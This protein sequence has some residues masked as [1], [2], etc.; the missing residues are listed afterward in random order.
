MFLL[1]P[2]RR[3]REV[4][5]YCLAYAARRTGMVLH[6]VVVMSNH[7]HLVVTDPL[8]ALP[9]FVECL[10]KLVA[11]SLNAAYG[12]WENFWASEPASYVR[13]L[14]ARAILDKIAYTLA[15]P[16]EA[17]LVRRGSEWPG[18]R[19][20]RAG[21]YPVA[22]PQGFFR[23]HGPMP[24]ALDLA[25]TPPPIGDDMAAAQAQV[26]QSVA[27][28]EEGER[29][30]IR[31]D[32]RSFLGAR[33]A[34]RQNPFASPSSPE[35]RHKLAPRIASRNKWVRV[36]ALARCAEFAKSYRRAFT[37]WREQNRLVLFPVGTYLMR[38]RHGVACA[39]A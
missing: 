20:G 37:A 21:T 26:D 11:K 4:F 5:H 8:G 23:E 39:P 7:Y 6:A 10:N 13:L 25:I 19:I 35:P 16:V 14:D 3:T 27:E 29:E 33:R 24:P 32:G 2:S 36:E 30:R 38:L 17:A 22:R 9:A 28:R 1:V 15:N 34:Q 31:R 12:R 18:L